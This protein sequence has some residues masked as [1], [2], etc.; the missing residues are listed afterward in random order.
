M[1]DSA[2]AEQ[3]AHLTDLANDI[4]LNIPKIYSKDSLK[5]YLNKIKNELH[6]EKITLVAIENNQIIYTSNNDFIKSLSTADLE[7][8]DFSETDETRF[9][10][11][12]GIRN[13]YLTKSI[14]EM[15][16]RLL[17]LEPEISIDH[18]ISTTLIK[19]LITSGII[20]IWVAIWIALIFG[21]VIAKHL[22]EKNIALKHQAMH[23]TLTNL[24]N[25]TLLMDRLKQA[26]LN[27]HRQL[28]PFV[29]I[30]LDLDS[31]KEIND[32]M[33]HHYGDE[34]LIEVSKR[35]LESIRENDSLARLGGDEFAIL[36][37]N[38]DYKGA[39][40]CAHRVLSILEQPLEINETLIEVKASL[41]IT[42]YPEHGDST[43]M[44]MQHAD[45]AMYQAKQI[46]GGSYSFYDPALDSNS[47]RRLKL[48]T[49][50]RHAIENNLL[51]VHYQPMIDQQQNCTI[52]V[53]V[54][55][56]WNDKEL[57]F[58]PPDEFIPIAEQTGTIRLLTLWVLNQATLDASHWKTLGHNIKIAVNI[59]TNCLQDASFPDKINQI[60][61]KNN[62][63]ASDIELEITES[64][65]MS[66]LSRARQIL[67]QLHELGFKISI[68]DFG[69]GFSSLAYLKQLPVDV[70]KIDRSFVE[71]MKNNKSDAAIVNTII[72]LAHSLNCKVVAE[73]IE[74][75]ET[76]DLLKELNNDIAQGYLISRPIPANDL[77]QWL[78]TSVWKPR[79]SVI[80]ETK[81]SG[82]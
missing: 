62:I 31:F 12:S 52:A 71:D 30:I 2:R 65:L 67:D 24:P 9:I 39:E 41:G 26:Q 40:I 75:A 70:L 22:K 79:Q 8:I 55:A 72:Q 49:N 60:I 7:I 28:S 35:L 16:Y 74:D 53:E 81:L 82:T 50:L 19:R 6:R 13:L 4:F 25:R 37:P 69:T 56:R 48:M 14:Q 10:S 29:L 78:E 1:L 45:V 42:L 23:D 76:Y 73:G 66:D 80:E 15:G 54:L 3:R 18:P 27:A 47:V 17:L 11:I 68:D 33:G 61:S 36:L 46:G 44:I 38:T 21:S 32:T 64:A 5:Q 43:D 63:L 59:S 34:L 51:N 77:E 57:G 58:I 20:I